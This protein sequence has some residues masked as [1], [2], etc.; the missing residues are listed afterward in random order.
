[1]EQL[2]WGLRVLLKHLEVV[3]SEL[4]FQHEG[5]VFVVLKMFLLPHEYSH[6][7][8]FSVLAHY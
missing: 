5:P 3:M 2:D 1:M 7:K 8:P 6:F 4:V